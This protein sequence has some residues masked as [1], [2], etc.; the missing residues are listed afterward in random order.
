MRL[1]DKVAIVAGA[2]S[3]GA[4]MSNGRASAILLAREGAKVVAVD[5]NLKAAEETVAA[6][7]ASGGRSDSRA[8]RCHP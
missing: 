4:E 7:K 1:T 5:K 2:G 8:G 6:I 3:R